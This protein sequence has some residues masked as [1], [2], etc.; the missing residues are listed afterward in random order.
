MPRLPVDKTHNRSNR[1][2]FRRSLGSNL[3]PAEAQLWT[4]LKDAQLEGRK[5]R[6]Q[7]S[8]GPYILDFYCPAE[9]LAVELNGDTHRGL[10]AQERDARREKFISDQGVKILSFENK[11]VFESPEYILDR[12]SESFGWAKK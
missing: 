10:L 7:H 4:L 8:V 6:R 2:E 9:R 3:T 5:F 11:L 12:I 1:K